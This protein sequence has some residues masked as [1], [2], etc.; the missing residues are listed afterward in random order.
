MHM[1]GRSNCFEVV[2]LDDLG[3]LANVVVVHAASCCYA[4]PSRRSVQSNLGVSAK[5]NA[6]SHPIKKQAMLIKHNVKISNFDYN[7]LIIISRSS[8]SKIEFHIYRFLL[9]IRLLSD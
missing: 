6:F 9:H 5:A 2:L 8:S 3:G 7:R 4:P 1:H